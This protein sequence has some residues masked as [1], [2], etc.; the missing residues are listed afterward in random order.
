[1]NNKI[2]NRK[3]F[4]LAEL[5]IVVAIIAVLTAIAVPLFVSALTKANDAVKDANIRAVRGEAISVILT[6]DVGDERVYIKDKK[7]LSDMA[8]GW[9]VEA[10]VNKDGTFV[11]DSFTI[12]PCT[13]TSTV[14]NDATESGGV[15]TVTVHIDMDSVIKKPASGST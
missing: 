8:N 15:W 10:K 11:K 1:M 12:T 2:R 7:T 13:T 6:C 3:G 14:K 4:T 9:D 5:L